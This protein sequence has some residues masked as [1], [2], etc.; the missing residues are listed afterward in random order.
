M[1]NDEQKAGAVKALTAVIDLLNSRR[2]AHRS[3]K[4]RTTSKFQ[5]IE[6]ALL[7]DYCLDLMKRVEALR[8]EILSEDSDE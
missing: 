3:E 2:I 1:T 8:D 7:E 4:N 6:A 5:Q